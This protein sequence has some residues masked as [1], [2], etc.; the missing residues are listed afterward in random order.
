M[1]V[2]FTNNFAPPSGLLPLL[3]FFTN[4]FAPPSGL[5]LPLL[6]FFTNN[7]APP[8]G[9]PAVVGVCNLALA[10]LNNEI[11]FRNLLPLLVFFTNNFA[12]PLLPF[13]AVVGVFHQQLPAVVGV[14]HQQLCAAVW[15]LTNGQLQPGT[16][17]PE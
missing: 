8:S 12:P 14:F 17:F 4:N 11:T 15:S 7:F 10:F 2:F 9:L 5:P 16:C 6:V 3:V 1:L 13:P